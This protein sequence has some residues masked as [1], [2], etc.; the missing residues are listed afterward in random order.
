[1]PEATLNSHTSLPPIRIGTHPDGGTFRVWNRLDHQQRLKW[2]AQWKRMDDDDCEPQ[3]YKHYEWQLRSA[4]EELEA[5]EDQLR[6]AIAFLTPEQ[7]E[8]ICPQPTR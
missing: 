7:L 5:R 3:H 4:I 8:T 6:K 2:K 1:M